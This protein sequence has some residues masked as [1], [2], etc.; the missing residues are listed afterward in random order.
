MPGP[1]FR[2]CAVLMAAYAGLYLVA[3]PWFGTGGTAHWNAPQFAVVVLLAWLA[4][5]G[6]RVARVLLIASSLAG[7]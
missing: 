1:W 5:R 4:A 7:F 6:S 2:R 3:G